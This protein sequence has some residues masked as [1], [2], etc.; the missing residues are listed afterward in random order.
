MAQQIVRPAVRIGAVRPKTSRALTAKPQDLLSYSQVKL[1]QYEQFGWE[2]SLGTSSD[3][4]GMLVM[5]FGAEDQ[6][7]THFDHMRKQDYLQM[8][9]LVIRKS[10]S[11][12][13]RWV[14]EV[15]P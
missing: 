7:R 13:P 8:S 15:A 2:V 5:S 3:K 10:T 6:A 1:Y 9:H 4:R 11:K 14:V 12:Q